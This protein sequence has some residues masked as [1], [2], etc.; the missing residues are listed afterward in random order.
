M[1][2]SFFQAHLFDRPLHLLLQDCSYIACLAFVHSAIEDRAER[3]G[4]LRITKVQCHAEEHSVAHQQMR[5]NGVVR[6]RVCLIRDLAQ[7]VW[8]CHLILPLLQ[9]AGMSLLANLQQCSP[10]D[11]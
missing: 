2:A 4:A 9:L 3:R 8:A 6:H 5:G 11:T 1:R 10:P 7:T